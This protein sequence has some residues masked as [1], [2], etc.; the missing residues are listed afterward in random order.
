MQR[1]LLSFIFLF[2]FS[3]NTVYSI[4]KKEGAPDTVQIGAY[5]LSLHDINFKD[6]EY[7][8]RLWLWML[9]Q[10]PEFDFTTQVEVPNAKS[11]EKPDVMVDT[12]DGDMGFDENEMYHEAKLESA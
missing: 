3:F 4:S 8:M 9:Y 11:I 6:K 2:T 7:T 12:I 1:L 10:N 5:V